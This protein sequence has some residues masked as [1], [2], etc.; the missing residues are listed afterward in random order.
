VGD[1]GGTNAR[2]SLW[3]SSATSHKE[4]YHHTFPTKDH[5]TFEDIVQTFLQQ[6]AAATS[7]AAQP[8][9]AAFACAGAV[10]N[11]TCPMTNTKL[12]VDGHQLSAA[13]GIPVA[14][15]NDFEAVGYGIPALT[16][17]DLVVV[18]DVPVV[19]EAPKVVMGPGTGL[20]AA[21]LMWDGGVKAYRVW[22][23]EGSHATFAPRGWKQQ[24]LERFVTAK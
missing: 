6:A 12:V 23:G 16:A 22:P 11:N 18:N 19:P 3:T 2:L 1:I 4:V 8:Q 9:S 14:V 10:E 13:L 5:D 20:G 15:L 24:A 7:S 17:A 21:Q